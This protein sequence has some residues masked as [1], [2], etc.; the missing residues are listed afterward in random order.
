WVKVDFA[1]VSTFISNHT[2]VQVL[3]STVDVL[4]PIG[5]T[6]ACIWLIRKQVSP[7]WI[8]LGLFLLGILGYMVG[9]LV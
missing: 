7:I 9:V 6:F 5:L 1:S 4:A 8:I 3:N 2:L